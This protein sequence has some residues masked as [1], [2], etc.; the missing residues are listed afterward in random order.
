MAQRVRVVP[1]ARGKVL[2]VGIGS[3]LNLPYYDSDQVEKVW[4]LDP[5]EELLAMA[6]SEAAQVDLEVE[7]ISERGEQIPLDDESF[8]T[9]VTTFTLCS[10]PDAPRALASMAR[11][12]KP[13][14]ELLF[15]EHG[16][17]PDESV[18]RW[19]NRLNPIWKRVGGGC[20]LNRPIPDLI[21]QNGFELTAV[22]AR[23]MPGWRWASYQYWGSAV[24]V[25][26]RR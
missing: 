1:K 5:S 19:Q 6:A 9:V 25:N 22:K 4:G 16:V 7:L 13:D 8:D 2:E 14:G 21:E 18:R 11:V 15:C 12:L 3:G 26:G 24:P 17:A 23:Y 10:I 20:H